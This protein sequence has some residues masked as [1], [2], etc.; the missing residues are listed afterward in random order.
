MKSK[1]L[2]L[3]LALP[4][5]CFGL[6]ESDS[7]RCNNGIVSVRDTKYEVLQKCGE[8]ARKEYVYRTY[9]YS[10]RAKTRSLEQWTYDFGKQE[11]VYLVNFD[12]GGIVSNL[13][14]TGSYGAK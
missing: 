7:M 11:F 6:G 1:L 2:I 4:S 13:Y 9:T 3:L 8:P 12:S 5:T 14:N 10:G